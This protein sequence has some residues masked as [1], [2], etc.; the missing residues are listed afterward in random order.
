MIIEQSAHVASETMP[1]GPY[2]TLAAG[3]QGRNGPWLHARKD[4]GT[5]RDL[6]ALRSAIAARPRPK[7]DAAKVPY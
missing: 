5:S 3:R 6:G 7:S 2:D 1:F 4:D